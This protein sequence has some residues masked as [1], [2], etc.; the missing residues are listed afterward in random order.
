MR[1][2]DLQ[3]GMDLIVELPTEGYKTIGNVDVI[4]VSPEDKDDFWM[5]FYTKSGETLVLTKKDYGV[6]WKINPYNV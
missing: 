5:Y 6:Y 4:I 2:E 3:K 1:F